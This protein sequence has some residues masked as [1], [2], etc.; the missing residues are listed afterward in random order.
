MVKAEGRPNDLLERIAADPAFGTTME[1]LQAIMNPK[2]FVGR[3]P[4][5]VS[6]FLDE[7]I[8]PILDENKE[9][10]GMTSEINV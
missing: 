6:E 3:A 2:N 10:L 4:E 7:V 9:A 1:E 8:Q 5:Q